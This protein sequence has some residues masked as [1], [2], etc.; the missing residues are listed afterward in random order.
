AGLRDPALR[1]VG[2]DPP[3]RGRAVLGEPLADRLAR[4]GRP[5]RDLA[6]L[7]VGEPPR[8]AGQGAADPARNAEEQAAER[9]PDH[10]LLPVPGAGGLLLR[11]ASL[12]LGHARPLGARDGRT[13]PAALADARPRGDLAPLP[14]SLMLPVAAIGTP[15]FFPRVSPRLVVRTGLLCLLAGTVVLLAALD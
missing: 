5:V 13:A 2:L 14:L 15:R 4:A 10:V 11:R 6:L 12:P 1:R 7:H 3:P 9:R 8:D